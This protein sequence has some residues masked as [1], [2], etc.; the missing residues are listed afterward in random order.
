MY[1]MYVLLLVGT[2][3]EIIGFRLLESLIWP[4]V[5]LCVVLKYILLMKCLIN[6]YQIIGEGDII[7][8]FRTFLPIGTQCLGKI[9][10]IVVVL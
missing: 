8:N 5:P 10:K 4:I 7:G 3:M 9:C 1:Y 2:F 6:I